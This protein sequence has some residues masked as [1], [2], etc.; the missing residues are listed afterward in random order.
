[1]LVWVHYHPRCSVATQLA[2]RTSEVMISYPSSP[3]TAGEDLSWYNLSAEA[4]VQSGLRTW[5]ADGAM[6]GS[7]LKNLRWVNVSSNW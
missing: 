3:P 6:E 7:G 4:S 2:T 1:M 5:T